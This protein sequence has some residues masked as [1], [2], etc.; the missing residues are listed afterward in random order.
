MH[1][2]SNLCPHVIV[3]PTSRQEDRKTWCGVFGCPYRSCDEC[4]EAH[5]LSVHFFAAPSAF[6]TTE[7]YESAQ[8]RGYWAERICRGKFA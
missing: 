2:E 3:L 7:N 5:I 6:R 4:Y 8:P 1:G